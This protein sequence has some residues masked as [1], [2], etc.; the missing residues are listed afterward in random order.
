MGRR[1]GWR[2]RGVRG[3]GGRRRSRGRGVRSW[4]MADLRVRWTMEVLTAEVLRE[5]LVVVVVFVTVVGVEFV[6]WHLR[7]RLRL[8]R[9]TS[10]SWITCA[11]W[12]SLSQQLYDA[13]AC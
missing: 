8:R 5:A 9:A 10:S 1:M 2:G 4:G 6:F 12:V 3:V 13:G 7:L 11:C